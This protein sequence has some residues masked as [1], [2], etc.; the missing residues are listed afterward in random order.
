MV[1]FSE[2]Q[3]GMLRAIRQVTP[4]VNSLPEK[5]RLK[6]LLELRAAFAEIKAV[7]TYTRSAFA[8]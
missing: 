8:F 5:F 6:V 7:V 2:Q 3:L 1:Q 4:E